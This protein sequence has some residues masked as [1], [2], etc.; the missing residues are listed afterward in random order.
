MT[1]V[2]NDDL[3]VAQGATINGDVQSSGNH[4]ILQNFQ[5]NGNQTVGGDFQVTGNETI[6]QNLEVAGSASIG[7]TLRAINRVVVSSTPTVPPVAPVLQQVRTYTSGNAAQ[8]GLMLTGT[9]GN[10]YMLFVDLSGGTPTLGLQRL[11]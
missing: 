11:L 9:D 8:P 1:M 3:F 10:S 6:T 5:V 7:S 2:I 4:T